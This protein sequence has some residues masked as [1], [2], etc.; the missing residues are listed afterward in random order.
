MDNGFIDT[1]AGYNI[2]ILNGLKCLSNQSIGPDNR[3][4]QT[5]IPNDQVHADNTRHRQVQNVPVPKLWQEEHKHT[6]G[7]AEAAA[8]YNMCGV[9]PQ[10]QV[11]AENC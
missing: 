2:L 4:R 5:I 6:P 3:H 1:Q 9:Q 7:M 11:Q 8:D 10:S